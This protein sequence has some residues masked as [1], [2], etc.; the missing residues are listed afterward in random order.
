VPGVPEVLVDRVH[1][2]LRVQVRRC[3][4]VGLGA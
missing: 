4:Y 3:R 2:M 1:G